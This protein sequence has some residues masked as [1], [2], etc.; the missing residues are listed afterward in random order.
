MRK[1]SLPS[2]DLY[3]YLI[4]AL[5]V[6]IPL[7]PKFPLFNI[8]GTYVAVRIEDFL[9][10]ISF[11]LFLPLFIKEF[12]KLIKN[13]VVRS[14]FIF[15]FIGFVSWVSAVFLTKT[16][17]PHIGLLHLL[18]RGQYLSLFL[19]GLIYVRN[20]YSKGFI[21]YIKKVLGLV[22]GF[23]FIYGLLQRYISFPIVITQNQEYSKGIALRW[24]TGSH[25]NS[26]FAGHYDLASYLVLILPIFV[27]GFFVFKDKG[28]KR[29]CATISLMGYW[30]LSSAVSRISI[31][32]FLVAGTIALF[33]LKKYKSIMIFGAISVILFGFSPGLRERYMR[34]IN[35]V[36]D[37]L[38]L[39]GTVYA[40]EGIV[41]DR[42]TS[43]RLNVEWPRAIRALKKNPLLG[44]GYS[45]I[46]LATDNDYLRALGEVGILGFSAFMLIFINIGKA[47]HKS[48]SLEKLSTYEKIFFVSILGGVVGILINAFFI[49]IFEASKLATSLWLLLGLLVGILGIKNN[50]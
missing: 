38:V 32:S 48:L 31:V 47:C 25:I 11:L 37:K 36:K 49:D 2:K 26:T 18:R 6:A 19:F 9:I 42:S 5:V 21:E 15:L 30:L 39:V 7:Y 50:Q 12:K 10:A 13:S 23:S 3:K 14:I 41:E 45:S 16:V 43:I 1:L 24:V 44:T 17:V 27:T 28:M 8:P 35:V 33:L 40:Q 34:I 46:T 20:F 29:F 22:V 4:T